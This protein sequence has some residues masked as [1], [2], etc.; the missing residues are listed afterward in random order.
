MSENNRGEKSNFWSGGT[1]PLYK[2]L[3]KGLKNKVWR[4]SVFLKNNYTCALCSTRSA[5][6]NPVVLNADHIKPFAIIFME[7]NL[8]SI[9]Q[10]LCC[11]DLW[12][13]DNGQTLCR[14]CHKE[15]TKID[16]II[17]REYKRKQLT[18]NN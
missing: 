18:T 13:V 1:H 7:N 9:E 16:T 11:D 6:G 12:D 8:T 14:P 10:A 5:K 17:I 3:R 15:K 2:L 4:E